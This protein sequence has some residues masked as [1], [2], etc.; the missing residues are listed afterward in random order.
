MGVQV[1]G[2]PAHV[3]AV[4]WSFCVQE[5]PSSQVVPSVAFVSTHLPLLCWQLAIWQ[6]TFE[7]GHM[8]GS[9]PWHE[10]PWQVYV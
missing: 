10:P 4:H 2:V 8:T 1:I 7:G 9:D 3:P 5:F 6:G